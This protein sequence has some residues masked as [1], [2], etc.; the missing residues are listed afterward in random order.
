MLKIKNLH[1][2]V[3]DKEILKGINL[4]INPGEV[5]AIMGPNG[6]GKSTLASVIAGKEDFEVTDGEIILENEEISELEADERAHKGIFL[7][8]QYPVEIPGVTVTNFMKTAINETRKAKG[9]EEMPASEMLKKIREKSELLEM[10]RKFLSRSLN[11]GF[12]GGE[13]KRNE[14]FQMAMLEPK[15]AILD[16]TDS[17]LDIDALRVVSNGVN[18]LRNKD[19]AVL[20]IT[21]YQRLLNYIE[22]DFVHVLLNGKIVKS[23]TKELALKLEE[24]GYDWLKKEAVND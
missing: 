20:V 12:S 23:G 13:K 22:P 19:N 16:E 4:E 18:K 24:Q 7:S 3:E 5:H 11:E 8:F 17:G 21:H 15:L 10:D 6:S 2:S 1:A 14:I 9:L